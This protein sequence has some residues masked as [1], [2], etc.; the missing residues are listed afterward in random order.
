MALALPCLTAPSIATARQSSIDHPLAQSR[1]HPWLFLT[2]V[3]ADRARQAVKQKAFADSAET[4]I[5]RAATN[6]I[7]DL[8][9]LETEWW[10]AA[11]LKPWKETYPEI[12][13]HTWK[14]PGTWSALALDC[15]RA[16]LLH[17]SPELENKAKEVLLR[18]SVYRFEF[19]HFDVGMNYTVW[20]AEALDA[21]DILYDRFNATERTQMDGFFMRMLAAVKKNDSYWV[22]EEPGGTVN[23]HYAWHKLC[24][25]MLGLF[26]ERP[27]LIDQ[28]FNGPKGIEFMLQHGF[29]DDGLW[30]EGSIGYQ[31]AA[32]EP[33]LQIAEL[34]ENAAARKQVV[35]ATTS[36]SSR[37]LYSLQT[38]DGR[39]LVQSYRALFPLLWPDRTLPTI[40]DAYGRRPH[41][42]THADF[43]S[44]FHRFHDPSFAW[45]LADYGKRSLTALFSGF[46]PLKPAVAPAQ[47]SKLWP[48]MGYVALRS[49]EGTNYWTGRGWS[50]FA[51]FSHRPI[52]QHADKLS[53]NVFGDGHLWLPDIEER[54]AAEHAF[55]SAVQSQLNRHTL[56]HNALLVDNESQKHPRQRLELLEYSSLPQVKRATFGDLK[57]QLYPGVRQLRTVIVTTNYIVDFFQVQSDQARQVAWLTHVDGTSVD[58]SMHDLAPTK[59]PAGAAWSYLRNAQAGEAEKHYSE[60]FRHG[61]VPQ[62]FRLDLWSDNPLQIVRCE[63]PL[64]ET[65]NS[66]TIPMRLA[67]TQA[68]KTWFLAVY[69]VGPPSGALEAKVEVGP[70]NTWKISLSNRA[71]LPGKAGS[72]I[73]ATNIV[74]RLPSP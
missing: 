35:P 5:R 11:K 38:S 31:F 41:L 53:L 26:Y 63:F 60:T 69:R 21:Y 33:M 66:E 2:T 24:Y 44:L 56:C 25:V 73:D 16:S 40:G 29:K 28:A 74:P 42:G 3:D 20:G 4:L 48:E 45:L 46:T 51:T 54:A 50:V 68:A 14:V 49:N 1:S 30:V 72:Q 23:N 67:Q 19:E 27:D 39:T 52:H 7:E 58:S 37:S 6:R 13:H 55:S 36:G 8:P 18:L 71:G 62:Q 17:R 64:N 70:L 59:L 57:G 61:S 43:E 10:N 65:E 12:Y 34:L 9:A 32:A 22:A 15:A 47:F